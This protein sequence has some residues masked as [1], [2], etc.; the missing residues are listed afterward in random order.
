M[1]PEKLTVTLA[2]GREP[3]RFYHLTQAEI[4]E[5]W[6]EIQR[7]CLPQTTLGWYDRECKWT[8]LSTRPNRIEVQS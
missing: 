5:V 2:V 1:H 3:I 7:H 4:A 8:Q 6:H